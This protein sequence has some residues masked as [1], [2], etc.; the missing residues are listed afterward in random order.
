MRTAYLWVSEY[1]SGSSVSIECL[2]Y[3]RCSALELAVSWSAIHNVTNIISREYNVSRRTWIEEGTGGMRPKGEGSWASGGRIGI[4][5]SLGVKTKEDLKE[6]QKD[7]ASQDLRGC[8]Y[9]IT[10]VMMKSLLQRCQAKWGL[11]YLSVGFIAA[12]KS[13]L[14]LLG[15]IWL[16]C[17]CSV[18]KFY[19][20]DDM[21]L[22]GRNLNNWKSMGKS[23]RLTIN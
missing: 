14:T 17:K 13:E 18:R 10:D 22:R 9:E 19:E 7:L 11:K 21:Q 23:E 2:L 20:E 4:S 6:D 8:G 16:M 12:R 5:L 3:A 1:N 15:L